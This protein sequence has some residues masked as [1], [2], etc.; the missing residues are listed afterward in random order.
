MDSQETLNSYSESQSA[1]AT[2]AD[3][4]T[5]APSA[6]SVDNQAPQV[7]VDP[8]EAT[9]AAAWQAPTNEAAYKWI[10]DQPLPADAIR[11]PEFETANRQALLHA[12][13]PDSIGSYL[14][15]LWHQAMLK[16]TPTD[17][18]LALSKASALHALEKKWGSETQANLT[19]AKSVVAKMAE[20]QPGVYRMLE[21]SGMGNNPWV[22]ETLA[23]L[24]QVQS[25]KG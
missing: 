10:P 18:Q 7:E 19:L 3:N 6:P 17:D 11:S 13:V 8:L 2:T 15:T 12:G 9:C 24:A 20:K 14:G 22:I 16:P 23:R 21:I 4:T 25:R 1:P 5:N